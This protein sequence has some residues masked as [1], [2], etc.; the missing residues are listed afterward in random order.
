MCS[1]NE[2]RSPEHGVQSRRLVVVQH[3]AMIDGFM[4]GTG[5]SGTADRSA[6]RNGAGALRFGTAG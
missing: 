5:D 2:S 3:P 1:A 4:S 6:M